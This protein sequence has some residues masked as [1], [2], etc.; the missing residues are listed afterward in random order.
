MKNRN[1]AQKP[2]SRIRNPKS[3]IQN[4]NGRVWNCHKK[5][6]YERILQQS[7]IQNP[8]GRVWNC[9]KKKGYE[10]ILQQ[11]QIQNP[12][13]RVW[14]C[15]IKNGY[16]KI[17]NPKSQIRN[18]KSKFQS[19]KSK[20]QTGRPRL[21]V[22]FS[23]WDGQGGGHPG[24]EDVWP[25]RPTDFPIIPNQRAN[26]QNFRPMSLFQHSPVEHSF[27]PKTF[28]SLTVVLPIQPVDKLGALV[29]VHVLQTVQPFK[30]SWRTIKSCGLLQVPRNLSTI[31]QPVVEDKVGNVSQACPS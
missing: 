13:G 4:P 20:I 28:E 1:G 21:D 16:Y 18:P 19:P 31:H 23:I 2:R 26:C 15:R 14:N 29:H 17:Q 8:N 30:R 27:L 6:G 25:S 9:H 5:K 7:K 12:N 3:S 24:N 10:R 22:G 11:S